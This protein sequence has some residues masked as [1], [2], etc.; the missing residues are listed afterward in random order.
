M[1]GPQGGGLVSSGGGV[2][3]PFIAPL[4]FQLGQS[5]SQGQDLATTDPSTGLPYVPSAGVL[6]R[7]N[8]PVIS[9][10]LAYPY[11]PHGLELSLSN[12]LSVAQGGGGT[13]I[14]NVKAA[15]N[16]S[17]LQSWLS[18]GANYATL[19]QGIVAAKAA[20]PLRRVMFVCQQGET[21]A[22]GGG[23]PG[24]YQAD[25]TTFMASVRALFGPEYQV[26]FYVIVVNPNTPSAP[27]LAQVRAAQDAACA[28]DTNATAVHT[29]DAIVPAL[30]GGLHYGAG[31]TFPMGSAVALAATLKYANGAAAAGIGVSADAS[32]GAILGARLKFLSE[33]WNGV[34]PTLITDQSGNGNN[35]AAVGLTVNPANALLNNLQTVDIPA[36]VT[37]T[38]VAL[39]TPT[40]GPGTP[41]TIFWLRR[42]ISHP[43]SAQFVDS[44]GFNND[45]ASAFDNNATQPSAQSFAGVLVSTGSGNTEPIGRWMFGVNQFSGQATDI[46]QAGRFSVQGNA[47]TT[48]ASGVVRKI[49]GYGVGNGAHIEEAVLGYC[50][51]ALSVS[52]LNRIKNFYAKKLN[53]ALTPLAPV[54]TGL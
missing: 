5:N 28:A 20:S 11:S 19:Q 31:Q 32:I 53:I 24:T 43:G 47:G 36:A 49:N 22:Q 42:L 50:I 9:Q 39:V 18:A 45:G 2:V 46:L 7:V 26:Y 17:S 38:N 12:A 13:P 29:F 41:W 21:E 16:G 35:F 48:A 23:S 1:R 30:A 33:T 27:N 37:A 54:A 10:L 44:S 15:V 52:E 40:P 25:F 8:Q 6:F 34:T 51:G 4:V 3:L 14:V